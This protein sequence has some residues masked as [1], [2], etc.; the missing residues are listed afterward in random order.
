MEDMFDYGDM[1]NIFVRMVLLIETYTD[2]L[3]IFYFI[4]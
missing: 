2:I 3:N 4:I 1:C